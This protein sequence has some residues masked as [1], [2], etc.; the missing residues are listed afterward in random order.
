[1]V[2]QGLA[3]LGARAGSVALLV[4]GDTALE[5]VSEFGYR[6]E[7]IGPW[8]RF[9]IDY[10]TPMS[11]AVRAATPIWLAS[12]A[13]RAARYPS[14]SPVASDDSAW[15]ALP[16]LAKGRPIGAI[17]LSFAQPRIFDAD[18]Q[19]FMLTLAQQ[20]AQALDRARLY[21]EAEAAVAARDE[22]LSVVSHDL[23]NPLAA[24]KGF[25]QLLRRRIARLD[26][27]ETPRLLDGLDKIDVATTRMGKQIA[28]LLDATRLHAGQPLD[29][30]H[31]PISL[32][33]L[34]RQVLAET[35]QTTQSHTIRLIAPEEELI[36]NYDPARLDR[37]FANLLQNAIKYSP[38][39]GAIGVELAREE[40]DGA[41]WAIVA[42]SDQGIGIPAEDLPQIFERFHRAGNVAGQIQGTG[43]GLSSASQIVHQHGGTIDVVSQ[44]GV[45]ST[46]TV[47]LPLE[48][49]SSEL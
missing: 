1:M 39:G 7:L 29:L 6:E 33:A 8:R 30:D 25:A 40:R 26:S 17:G 36:G 34:V 3:V 45:G 32:V 13:E 11:D 28:E 24:V 19:A 5:V 2:A 38:R 31:Q 48:P 9:S 47:R 44:E 35:Q 10:P 42:V 18:D 37:V 14:W 27:P 15:V 16:L 49:V 12:P 22:L 46:F 43:I 21:V 23:K 41:S 4:A 20:C